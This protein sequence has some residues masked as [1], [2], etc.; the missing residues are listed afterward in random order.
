[1][2]IKGDIPIAAGLSSSS[3][4]AVAA[5][6]SFSNIMGV[7]MT[8]REIADT[9]FHAEVE[10]FGESGG[11]MDHYASVFGQ[12]LYLDSSGPTLLPAI[13]GGFVI[14]DSLEPKTDTVGDLAKIREEAEEGYRLLGTH[15]QDFDRRTTS[16]DEIE[17]YTELLPDSCRLTT[18]TTMQNRDLTYRAREML[19]SP[20]PNPEVLGKMID[21][22]HALLRDGLHR[23]TDKIEH[24]I[25]A[26]K[27]S[28]A[29]GCKINGSGG[30]GTMV[31]YAPGCE[32]AVA[33]AIESAGGVAYTVEIGQGATLTIL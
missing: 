3:A 23:S 25:G 21:Q 17:K 30:G 26:A 29:L 15:I 2:T 16:L 13:L 27:E 18:I 33:E 6:L 12:P 4:L 9:A 20:R 5:V 19:S 22:H 32:S 11:K 24:M 8:K 28:G 14:G 7:K 1:L 31:A 10:E